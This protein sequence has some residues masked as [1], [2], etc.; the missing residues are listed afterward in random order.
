MA[1]CLQV[2]IKQKINREFEMVAKFLLE[3]MSSLMNQ[4]FDIRI[5]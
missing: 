2:G 3:E 5:E 4:Y 1:L